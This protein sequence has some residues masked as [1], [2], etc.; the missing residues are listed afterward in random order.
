MALEMLD[1]GPVAILQHLD[2][3]LVLRAEV[4][5]HP[6]VGDAH[7]LRDLDQGAV[8]V[9][10]GPER[11]HRRPQDLLAAPGGFGTGP[12][13][14]GRSSPCGGRSSPCD[15]TVQ[16]VRR[17]ILHVAHGSRLYVI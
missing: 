16:A 4:M 13:C 11:R 14:A 12:P 3:Q 8:V 17:C 1:V 9:A 10:L 5:Q 6:G 7:L 15:R 2:E